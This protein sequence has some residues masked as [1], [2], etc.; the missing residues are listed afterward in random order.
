MS[1]RQWMRRMTVEDIAAAK[2][3][4]EEKTE[5]EILQL[6]VASVK[7][8]SLIRA[9]FLISCAV[10]VLTLAAPAFWPSI[11]NT[12][13][14]LW[15]AAMIAAMLLPTPASVAARRHDREGRIIALAFWIKKDPSLLRRHR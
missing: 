12:D 1:M 5:P 10:P 8:S 11:M 4:S 7:R 3:L 14:L 15:M 6:A 2:R 13:F 9:W